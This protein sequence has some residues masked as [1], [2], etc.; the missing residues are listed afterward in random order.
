MSI[1]QLDLELPLRY[2]IGSVNHYGL[3][4]FFIGATMPYVETWIDLKDFEDDD[5]IE[6]VM[7]RGYKVTKDHVIDNISV[8]ELYKDL[9]A[10]GWTDA[11]KEEIAEFLR[12]NYCV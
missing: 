12:E 2:S 11:V 9:N 5:L 4:S 3:R 10:F 6:E 7:R 8:A 1:R